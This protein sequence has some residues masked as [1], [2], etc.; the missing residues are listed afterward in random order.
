V[1][2]ERPTFEGISFL[3]VLVTNNTSLSTPFSLVEIEMVIKDNDGTRILT[4]MGSILLLPNVLKFDEGMQL[5]QKGLLYYFLDLISKIEPPMAYVTLGRQ[6]NLVICIKLK[7]CY[8]FRWQ[9][10]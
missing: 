2:W 10:G 1:F 3:R 8:F 6:H 7:P 4:S 9:N 5:F